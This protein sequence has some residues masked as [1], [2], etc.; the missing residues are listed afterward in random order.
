MYNILYVAMVALELDSYNLPEM[1]T[2]CCS[3]CNI[4]TFFCRFGEICVLFGLKL[5]KYSIHD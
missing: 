4:P 3:A 2:I 1:S 5:I